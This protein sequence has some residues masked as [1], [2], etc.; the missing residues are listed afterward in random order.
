[1]AGL[2][3]KRII[4]SIIIFSSI[5]IVGIFINL[6]NSGKDISG[7]KTSEEDERD[8]I[9]DVLERAKKHGKKLEIISDTKIG[10][11]IFALNFKGLSH[12]DTNEEILNLLSGSKLKSTFFV[13]GID[14]MENSEFIKKLDLA[15][16]S[17]A[18]NTLSGKK[19]ME[20]LSHEDLAREFVRSSNI[21]ESLTKKKPA[22]LLLNSTIYTDDLLRIAY[23][24]GY[25][26]IVHS[27]HILNYQSFKNY[28][29]VL[30]YIKSLEKGTIINIK[31]DG[32]LDEMEYEAPIKRGKAETDKKI[33]TDIV[34][35][36]DL[37]TVTEQQGL[38]NLVKWILQAIEEVDYKIDY[39]EN[40]HSYGKEDYKKEL[41]KKEPDLK[42]GDEIGL[43]YEYNRVKTNRELPSNVINIPDYLYTIEELDLL[44]KKNNGK[45]A[46]ELYTIYTT[47]K[48]VNF[49][50]YGIS[51]RDALK[52]TLDKLDELDIKGTFFI[53]EKEFLDNEDEIVY[54]SQNG[55]EIGISLKESMDTDYY[56][57][58]EKILK[59]QKKA[60]DLTGKYPSLF[61]Y[62]YDIKIE[63]DIL[64]AI[65]TVKGKVVWD[66]LSVASSKIGRDGDLED[67]IKNIFNEG[68]LFVRRGYIIYSRMDFYSDPDLIA[69]VVDNIVKNRVNTLRYPEDTKGVSAY[70]IKTLGDILKGEKTYNYPLKDEERLASVKGKIYPGH[71]DRL[72][73]EEK[74]NM[75]K[76]RYIGNPNI[77]SET[78]LPGFTDEELEEIDTEGLVTDEKVL[79]LTFDDW[80]SDKPVN[81]IL[82]VL[83]KHNISSSFFIRTNYVKHNPN[84]L[85]AIGEAGHDIGSHTHD[86][87]PFALTKEKVDEDDSK[88]IYFSITD[89]DAKE[90]QKDLILSY[91]KLE[92][93]VG[94]IAVDGKPVLN[95]IFRP[96]TLAM[97][98][99]GMEAV[100]DT[101]FSHIVSGDFSTGDYQESDPQVIA[102]K[103]IKGITKSDGS[104]RELQNGSVLIMHM[105]DG[106]KIISDSSNI[107]AKALDIAIPILKS[108]GYRFAKLSDYIEESSVKQ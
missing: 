87:L 30:G 100:F 76:E 82:Y 33:I 31:M 18:S 21:I 6:Y 60:R 32:V 46:E 9:E 69:D 93:I 54:I 4:T 22:S 96:P 1:M 102:D 49:S 10:E 26:N 73:E 91:N 7:N 45:K 98:R 56:V 37:E 79:F 28:E 52:S 27:N 53:N 61:R 84:L 70:S 86:H 51:N 59:M 62:P 2:N 65:S 39:A 13:T 44:R 5:L 24:S 8:L 12:R 89:E 64:E 99:R 75:L 66:D 3:K 34:E 92:S 105:T 95:R 42:R 72:S 81:Q 19:H 103:I 20:K 47:E 38:L 41:V 101:G 48:A 25:E 36:E 71:L 67:I 50:F 55:H 83:D 57:V 11:N 78:T 68:N 90:R 15:G 94:D 85:R 107:T 88:A 97:S 17:I 63:N 35:D 14:G 29:Q 77:T 43:S 74:F 16:I 80:S 58:L 108:K 40:L 104:L 23:E 106:D